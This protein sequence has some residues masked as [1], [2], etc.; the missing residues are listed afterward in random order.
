MLSSPD[1]A[2]TAQLPK[3]E[4]TTEPEH[5]PITLEGVPVRGAKYDRDK[6][7]YTLILA[8][9]PDPANRKTAVYYEITAEGIK[10]EELYI[11]YVT[12]SRVPVRVTGH[13][14]SYTQTR[15]GKP[16]KSVRLINGESI[17]KIRERWDSP[18]ILPEKVRLADL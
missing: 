3:I 6:Q 9:H 1:N 17:E 13:D 11:A 2:E 8:H 7:K 5:P 16:E 18:D 15:K 14:H 4:Q 12:D 10:A